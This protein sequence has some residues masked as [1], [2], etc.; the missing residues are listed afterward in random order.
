MVAITA[1][2]K[3]LIRKNNGNLAEE[4]HKL[5]EETFNKA[6]TLISI[7]D[8]FFNSYFSSGAYAE[9]EPKYFDITEGHR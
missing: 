7:T 5:L 8:D 3:L 1:G 2:L 9:I 6:K 4:S